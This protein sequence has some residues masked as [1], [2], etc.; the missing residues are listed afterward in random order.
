MIRDMNWR[1]S[2]SPLLDDSHRAEQQ[3][4]TERDM[5]TEKKHYLPKTIGYKKCKILMAA[6]IGE[7]G[8]IKKYRWRELNR[9][10]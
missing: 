3:H 10:M 5:T 1:P 4:Q 9:P 7:T 8:I 6:G 2:S